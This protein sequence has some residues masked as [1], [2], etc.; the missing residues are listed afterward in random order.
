MGRF[1]D[2]RHYDQVVHDISFHLD[3]HL[4]FL[5]QG[6]HDSISEVGRAKKVA[7]N[8]SLAKIMQV[9]QDCPLWVSTSIHFFLG[10]LLKLDM[11]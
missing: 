1:V 10:L 6:L 7:Q 3:K 5:D 4:S 8:V 11:N 9:L 2:Q